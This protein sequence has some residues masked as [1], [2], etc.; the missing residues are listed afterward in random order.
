MFGGSNLSCSGDAAV[1]DGWRVATSSEVKVQ[2]CFHAS[3]VCETQ[4]VHT[5]QS[6]HRVQ[7]ACTHC[8]DSLVNKWPCFSLLF[9][10]FTPVILKAPD[11]LKCDA[12]TGG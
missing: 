12:M 2:E 6:K 11:I 3:A 1:P 10:R 4:S 9:Y 8:P 7:P 5:E